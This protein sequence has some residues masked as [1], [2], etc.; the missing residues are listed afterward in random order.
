MLKKLTLRQIEVFVSA[1]RLGSFGGAA[2]ELGVTQP[3]L[4]QAV[5]D[6]ELDYGAQLFDRSTRP[7]TLTP[8][9][10]QFLPA[11]ERVVN[12]Y[13]AA[14]ANLDDLASGRQGQVT[15]SSLQSVA[16][17]FFPAVL[18]QFSREQPGLVVD[19][20]ENKADE[21]AQS[22]RAGLVDFGLSNVTEVDSELDAKSLLTDRFVLVCR[23]DHPLAAQTAVQWRELA[24]LPM[25]AMPRSAGIW[26]QLEPAVERAGQP[27][28][29]RY[30]AANPGTVLALVESGIGIATLPS[31]AWPRGGHPHLVRR[32]LIDPVVERKIYLLRRK[33]DPLGPAAALLAGHIEAYAAQ[34]PVVVDAN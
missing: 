3:A 23:E 19:L 12:A 28:D 4:S 18:A 26:R 29:V 2:D 13:Q 32:P 11:A 17:G 10:K 20:R 8:L 7:V 14:R 15:V 30:W 33:G 21:V 27:M 24:G 34:T 1:A 9:G 5:R 22:V 6:L 16:V 31:L 25:V